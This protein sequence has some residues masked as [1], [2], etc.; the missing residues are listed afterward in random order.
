MRPRVFGKDEGSVKGGIYIYCIIQSG[1]HLSFGPIGIGGNGDDVYTLSYRDMS[2]VVSRTAVRKWSVTRENV[3]P[4]KRVVEEVMRTHTV[5][6]V[7][8]ATIAEDENKVSRI[9]EREYER[10]LDLLSYMDG[11]KEFGLKTMFKDNTIYQDILEKHDD[12]RLLKQKIAV[13]SPEKT[14]YQRMEIGGMVEAAMEKER[15]SCREAMLAALT[16]L[17]VEVKT[18]KV[19]GEQMIL[20]AAFLV[21][22]EAEKAFDDAV[23]NLTGRYGETVRF[24]YAGLLPPFSFVNLVVRTE[25]N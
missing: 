22:K 5:L 18:N 15:A 13:L 23:A 10:F 19:Y 17:A 6:P 2:A 25:D 24:K 11:K 3:M 7:R 9:L 8:F 20:N 16:P 21:E 14:Q 1:A 12:I 4:H